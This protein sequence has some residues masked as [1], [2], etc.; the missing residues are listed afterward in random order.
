MPK[1]TAASRPSRR[2]E[3][4]AGVH[5]GVKETVAH[6]MAQEGLDQGAAETRQIRARAPQGLDIG[7]RNAVD[8]FQRH[9]FAGAAVPIDLRH[10]K[11]VVAMGVFGEFRRRGGLKPEIHLDLDRA[12]Q[13]VD[14]ADRIEPLRL[15]GKSL[16]PWRAAK[17]MSPRSRRKRRSMPGR[18]TLTATGC[19]TPSSTTVARWTCATEAAATGSLNSRKELADRPPERLFDHPD[20]DVARKTAP[21]GPEALRARAPPSTPTTSGRVARRLAELDVGRAELGDRRREPRH[22]AAP[23]RQQPGEPQRRVAPPPAG[24][25]RRRRKKRLR[26]PE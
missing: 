20:R 4:I 21:S 10:Q 25:R 26:A 13:S 8:P 19:S 5:V 23:P 1:S 14:H 6:R 2:Q 17:N 18:S 24:R 9:D 11:I 7:Q 12:G 15:G 16:R 22:A 3:Q